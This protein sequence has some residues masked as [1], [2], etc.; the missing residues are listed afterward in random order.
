MANRTLANLSTA[1]AKLLGAYQAKEL[2]FRNPVTYLAFILSSNI[3][4]PNYSEL[5]LREDRAINTNYKVRSSRALGTGGRIHNH[6]GVKGDTAVLTP[7]W[8]SYDDKFKISLK[9]ADNSLYSLDEQLASELQEITS[10][11]AEGL[12][13]IA[14]A[15]IFAQRSGVNIAT[16]EGAFDA[17]DDAF[18][19]TESTNGDR[20][21]QISKSVMHVNKYSDSNLVA[22]CDTVAYNKFL[23]QAAQGAQNS[24]N[25]S[26]QFNG[27]TYIHSVE[28]GALGAG[29][30]SAYAKGFWIMA[31]MGTFGVLPWIPKQNRQGVSTKVNMFDSII[32]PIDNQIYAVHSYETLATDAAANGSAQ[33]V[34]TQYEVSIDIALEKAPLTTAN[35]T[36][37]Q[38]FALV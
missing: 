25:L 24:T 6:S 1:Q 5:R 17:V 8:S 13:T 37:F 28:L 12:E 36:V 29:L 33:D 26:F 3:M 20:A 30:V 23:F 31:E 34:V 14:T 7:S 32:N 2:R 38:A 4:F 35:E 27:V 15:Y 18:E 11:F 21:I 9:Q 16:A 10:N 19:I 22:F